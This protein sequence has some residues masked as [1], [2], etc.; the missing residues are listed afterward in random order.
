MDIYNRIKTFISRNEL[1]APGQHVVAGVSG[2]PDSITLLDGLVHLGYRVTAAHFDHQIRSESGSDAEFV[3]DLANQYQCDCVIERAGEGKL[4][5]PGLSLEEAARIFRYRFLWRTAA[6]LNADA[7]AVGHISGD[8]VETILMHL[9]RGAGSSGLRGMQPSIPM[10]QWAEGR[11]D[12]KAKDITLIRPILF[13]TRDETIQ[14]CADLKITPRWDPSNLD[15]TFFRNRLRH[16]LLPLLETYNAGVRKHLLQIGEIMTEQEKWISSVVKRSLSQC[17]RKSSPDSYAINR[18]V[19]KSMP[20]ALQRAMILNILHRLLPEERNL[21]Y[22]VVDSLVEGI[23]NGQP[24]R[25]PVI[26]NFE[27]VQAGEEVLICPGYES[28]DFPQYPLLHSSRTIEMICSMNG[29]IS[30]G[31]WWA[32]TYKSIRDRDDLKI[33]NIISE[34]NIGYAGFDISQIEGSLVVRGRKAGDR[35]RI[36]KHSHTK[37]VSDVLM[38]AKIPAFLRDRWPMVC[39]STSILWIPGIRRGGEAFLLDSTQ[40]AV[41]MKLKHPLQNLFLEKS[42]SQV[43]TD[44]VEKPER[45]VKKLQ[46]LN[47]LAIPDAADELGWSVGSLEADILEWQRKY[48]ISLADKKREGSPNNQF[49]INA[50]GRQIIQQYLNLTR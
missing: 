44:V 39:D 33:G 3:A 14:H 46:I 17:C 19:F 48:G 38:E 34:L 11:T 23:K 5:Q 16:E 15:Q 6:R 31:K 42:E 13:L 2:G 29:E 35:I 8:Q 9:L 22:A 4:D 10:N 37:K 20:T 50:E 12:E 43:N 21:T 45:N 24:R 18:K 28:V 27:M 26:S 40:D 25:L 36:D 41:F 32:L 1:L 30:L 49:V 47:Q 7:V